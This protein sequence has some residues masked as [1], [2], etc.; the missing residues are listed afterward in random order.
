VNLDA[1]SRSGETLVN[2][3]HQSGESPGADGHFAGEH[4]Y[5]ACHQTSATPSVSHHPWQA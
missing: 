1:V 5:T 4:T 3:T 2:K